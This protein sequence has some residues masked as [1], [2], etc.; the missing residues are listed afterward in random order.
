MCIY[1]KLLNFFCRKCP[2]RNDGY[3]KISFSQEGEDLIL[4]RLLNG[5]TK[6]FYVDVGAYHPKRFSNTYFFYMRGWR[7][8]NIDAMPGSMEIF[9]LIRPDDI[10]LEIAV[11][12]TNEEMTFYVFE[13]TALNTFCKE[14]AE[15]YIN[16]GYKLNL[17]KIIQTQTLADV[18][19]RY[20]P[21][22]Q[23]INFLNIDVEELDYKVLKSNNWQ[24]Y[25]PGVVLIEELE[26]NFEQLD[27]SKIVCFM[28]SQGYTLN[29][30]TVNTLIFSKA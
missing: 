22:N 17:T 20:L 28:K 3:S 12:D 29:C 27:D 23:T 5:K 6:G 10:N 13:E 25:D 9:K 16:I 8:I 24:K 18:L 11:S 15:E 1:K 14:L 19:D 2:Y 4:D 30:K 26:R 21:K 7:G